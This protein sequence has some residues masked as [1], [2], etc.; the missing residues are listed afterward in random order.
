MYKKRLN[1]FF[2]NLP[3][4]SLRGVAYDLMLFFLI[5]FIRFPRDFL[6]D[7]STHLASSSLSTCSTAIILHGLSLAVDLTYPEL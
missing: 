5:H 4:P 7:S 1:S 6:R 2:E 3:F